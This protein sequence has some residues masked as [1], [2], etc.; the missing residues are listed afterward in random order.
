MQLHGKRCTSQVQSLQQLSLHLQSKGSKMTQSQPDHDGNTWQKDRKDI[1]W[2]VGIHEGILKDAR[3]G[4]YFLEIFM[5]MCSL[6]FSTSWPYFRWINTYHFPHQF[7]GHGIWKMCMMKS[8]IWKSKLSGS[9]LESK[10]KGV[11]NHFSIC[12]C[13]KFRDL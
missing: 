9:H 6:M 7:F 12:Y 11:E 3:G 13:C 8:M 10:K 2:K 5:E 4:F 1:V